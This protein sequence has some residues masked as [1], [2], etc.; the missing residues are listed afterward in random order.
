MQRHHNFFMRS[1]AKLGLSMG[2]PKR[3][4]LLK[5]LGLNED[6]FKKEGSRFKKNFGALLLTLHAVLSK[7]MKQE[8]QPIDIKV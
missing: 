2:F 3:P 6:E 4:E 8:D 7:E 5:R 1:A